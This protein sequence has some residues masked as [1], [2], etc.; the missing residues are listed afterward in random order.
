MLFNKRGQFYIIISVILAIAVFS[1]TSN[2]NIIQEAILFESFESLSNNYIHESGYVVNS[3]LKNEVDVEAEL[4]AFTLKYLEYSKQRA[5]NLNLLYIYSDPI[6]EKIVLVNYFDEEVYIGDVSLS[7]YE[8]P[9][10]QDVTIEVGGNDFSHK[11]PVKMGEFGYDWYSDPTLPQNFDLGVAGFLHT[12]DLSSNG[13][14]FRIIINLENGE[15]V[16]HEDFGGTGEYPFESPPGESDT[17]KYIPRQV[18][19]R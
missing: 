15:Q 2:P 13:P 6:N 17:F 18:K 10:I 3:A 7:G 19:T 4:E 11:V 5:P 14:E 1:V 16:V 9:V 12:F 8:E